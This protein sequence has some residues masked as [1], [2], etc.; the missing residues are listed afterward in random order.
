M[1]S[2]AKDQKG[3]AAA[4]LAPGKAVA[5]GLPKTAQ[6]KFVVQPEKPGGSVSYG[7]LIS[8]KIEEAGTYRVALN[9]AAWIDVLEER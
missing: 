8:F 5:A 2:A 3:L 7:G 1:L 6:V 9:S 4:T